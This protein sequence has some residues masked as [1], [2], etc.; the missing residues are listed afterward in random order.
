[1]S[2][3]LTK[4][5][6]PSVPV[7]FEAEGAEALKLK[8]SWTMKAVMT[9][10]RKLRELGDD[11]NVLQLG[12]FWNGMDASRLAVSI[13]ACAMQDQPQYADAEGLEII[14]SYITP[15]NYPVANLALKEA[16]LESLSEKRRAEIRAAEEE[17]EAQGKNGAGPPKVE[18]SPADPI[19]PQAR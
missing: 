10:E 13:W 2:S 11:V 5:L 17:A 19:P 12:Q 9:I 18:A 8:L 15:E 3:K 1:M 16:F 7:V 14:A 6:A 4:L